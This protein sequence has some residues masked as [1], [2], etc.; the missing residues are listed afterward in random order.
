VLNKEI[1]EVKKRD[2]ISKF[3]K[4]MIDNKYLEKYE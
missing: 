1:S 3:L 2:E 4:K